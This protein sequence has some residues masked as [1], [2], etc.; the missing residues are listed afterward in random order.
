MHCKV[1]IIF[2]VTISGVLEFY[3][4]QEGGNPTVGRRRNMVFKIEDPAKS[5]T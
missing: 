5:V 4:T 2:L 3:D 1:S